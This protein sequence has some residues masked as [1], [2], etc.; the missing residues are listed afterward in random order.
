MPA[1]LAPLVYSEALSVP[2]AAA[3]YTPGREFRRAGPSVSPETVLERH[4]RV[5]LPMPVSAH[6][7]PV[8][9][10]TLGLGKASTLGLGK[11]QA[12]TLG[13]GKGGTRQDGSSVGLDPRRPP[14]RSWNAIPA[15]RC[16]CPYLPIT[17]RSSHLP[18]AWA[19]AGRH[20][21]PRP[22]QAARGFRR[23]TGE[24][25]VEAGPPDLPAQ[26]SSS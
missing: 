1:A 21:Y 13:L 15:S 24:P 11:G 18:S 19:S 17:G 6:H 16:P 23:E 9:T 25:S 10:S 4:P 2:P 3:R 20:I 5:P 22:G 26:W 12:S 14:K 7:G 8:V